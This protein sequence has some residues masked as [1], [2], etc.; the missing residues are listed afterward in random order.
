MGMHVEVNSKIRVSFNDSFY[1]HNGSDATQKSFNLVFKILNFIYGKVETYCDSLKSKE[2][3]KPKKLEKELTKTLN[4][5]DTSPKMKYL[6]RG[7]NNRSRISRASSNSSLHKATA[8]Q[9][10]SEKYTS[11]AEVKTRFMKSSSRLSLL[12][13]LWGKL[14]YKLGVFKN[15]LWNMNL[16][17]DFSDMNKTV[18]GRY[19]TYY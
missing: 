1:F 4:H 17:H 12:H 11:I 13:L 6:S 16:F 19:N 14:I 5:T 18:A 8:D 7:E 15:R 2:P 10:D 9:L 3:C